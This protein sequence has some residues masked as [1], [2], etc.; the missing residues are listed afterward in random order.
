MH[1]GTFPNTWTEWMNASHWGGGMLIATYRLWDYQWSG[2]KGGVAAVGFVPY[3]AAP[4]LSPC[5]LPTPL[6]TASPPVFLGPHLW[7]MEVP[8]LGS[9]WE[10][11]LR[12]KPQ[13][14]KRCIPAASV[15]YTT[16]FGNGASLTRWARPGIKPS[17]SLTLCWVLNLLS[18]NSSSAT[19]FFIDSTVT[20]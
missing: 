7:H 2:I 17:S 11:Q 15:T 20:H 4:S 6:V 10:L 9:N 14:Q 5:L 8:R 13:P 19:P 12:P 16:V 1:L 18:H 3:D